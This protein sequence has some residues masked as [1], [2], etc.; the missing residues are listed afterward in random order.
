MRSSL[1]EA[2]VRR[3]AGAERARAGARSRVRLRPPEQ[4]DPPVYSRRYEECIAQ[5][6][7]LELDRYSSRRTLA[8]NRTSSSARTRGRGAPPHS[9]HVRA[10]APR[11]RGGSALGGR[12]G[13]MRAFW[14]RWLEIERGRPDYAHGPAGVAWLKGRPRAGHR[15]IGICTSGGAPGSAASRSSRSGTGAGGSAFPGDPA[16]PAGRRVPASRAPVGRPRPP[17]P[18]RNLAPRGPAG[19]Q[20]Y[21]FG[22]EAVRA[23]ETER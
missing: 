18:P 10:E 22:D 4:G 8:R 21:S 11:G 6:K 20:G 5:S 17:A 13:G 12:A 9:A 15:R 23:R 2:R 14:R 16:R 7:R 3:G 1:A 19:P